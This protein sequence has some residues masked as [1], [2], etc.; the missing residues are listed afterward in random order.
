M[1]RREFLKKAGVGSVMLA[2]FPAF[3]ELAQAASPQTNFHFVAISQ[4][5]TI[6]GVAH[7]IGMSGDGKVT[8]GSVVGGGT[9][10]HFDQNSPLPRT[11]FATGN[12]KAKEL[13]SFDL[14][15]TWGSFA[16]GIVEMGIH[17]V[18]AGGSPIPATLKMVCNLG[19]ANLFNPGEAEGYTL[20]VP[21]APFGPFVP[22][23]PALGLTLFTTVNEQRD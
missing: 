10:N 11:I 19:F 21:G 8:P 18:P 20:T 7:W 15:G 23:V 16:A 22:F 1:Q 4:A 12:W 9:F 2:S 3:A 17:L 5:S 14:I 13:L 6:G